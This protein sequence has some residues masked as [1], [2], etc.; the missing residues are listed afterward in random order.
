MHLG[1]SNGGF[2]DK[3]RCHAGP[4]QVVERVSNAQY[5]VQGSDRIP[6]IIHAAKL[7]KYR[8]SYADINGQGHLAASAVGAAQA[9]LFRYNGSFDVEV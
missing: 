5:K 1:D 9:R 3:L 4:F 7:L 8:L 6:V 2:G